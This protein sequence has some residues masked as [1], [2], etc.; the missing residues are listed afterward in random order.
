MEIVESVQRG[1]HSLGYTRGRLMADPACKEAWS[2]HFLHHFN[3]LNIEAIEGATKASR[4]R[5]I[6]HEA[7]LARRLLA[8]RCMAAFTS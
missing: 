5:K 6:D 2:E 1:L 7:A 4:H 8:R 3:R